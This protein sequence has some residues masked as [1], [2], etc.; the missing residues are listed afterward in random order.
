MR[1]FEDLICGV[2]WLHMTENVNEQEHKY[3]KEQ[4]E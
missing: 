1:I 3:E 2:N 4:I